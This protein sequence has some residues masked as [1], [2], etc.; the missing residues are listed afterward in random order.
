MLCEKWGNLLY[1]RGVNGSR[2]LAPIGP[3]AS[4]RENEYSLKSLSYCERDFGHE[5]EHETMEQGT[6]TTS[7]KLDLPEASYDQEWCRRRRR[8]HGLLLT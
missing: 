1:V 6:Y 7:Y 2:H 5:L 3:V 4:D 8:L